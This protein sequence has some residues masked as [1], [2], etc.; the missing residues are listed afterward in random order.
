MNLES[1]LSNTALYILLFLIVAIAISYLVYFF[2]KDKEEFTGIQ[3]LTLTTVRFLYTF[4][5][6]FL[7]ISP[8]IELIKKRIEKPILILGIDNSE[9]MENDTTYRSALISLNENV[10][11]EAGD[12]F[13]IDYY[14]FG[15]TVTP[16]GTLTFS[17]KISNYSN[18]FNELE[19]RYFNLNIG[20]IIMAG[21]GIYNEGKNPVQEA[22]A[23]M[24]P[25]YT[26][27]IGDTLTDSDQAIIN[28]NHNPN[29]FMGNTFPLEIEALFKKVDAPSTQLSVYIENSLI[30]SEKID[31]P[32]PDYYYKKTLRLN[33]EEPGLQTVNVL[34]TPLPNE[35]N[36]ANNRAGFSI[37][38]HE[39]KYEVLVLTQSPHPDIGAI[40]ETLKQQAN[41]K[42]TN[43]DISTFDDTLSNFDIVVLNQLP[44]LNI[45]E[46][47]H[48]LSLKENT[49]L[50]VL[51]ITGPQTSISAFNNL[52]LGL[53]MAPSEITEESSPYFNAGF[54]LF[55]LPQN[56]NSV[57]PYYPPLLT[58]YTQ[59]EYSGEFAELAFQKING[60]EMDYPLI[61]T[62]EVDQRK[63]AVITGEGIWRWKLHEYQNTGKHQTFNQLFVSLFNYLCLK[64]EREQFKLEYPK[65]A[66]ETSPYKIKAQVFNEIY[67]PVTTTEVKL[68]LTDSTGAELNYIFDSDNISYNLNMGYLTP[69]KYSFIAST[70]LGEKTFKQSGNFNIQEINVEQ[71]N[72][73]ADFMLLKNISEQTGGKFFYP[74]QIDDLIN[75]IAKNKGIEIKIH[76][77]KNISEII[78]WKW[79]LFIVIF[80][81]SLEWFLRKFWGS[82]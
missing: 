63:T 32:Q 34:L 8:V 60:I 82:Y 44:S 6:V 25:I 80:L 68:I 62:G 26:I 47:K 39:N 48:F 76:N 49:T 11:S 14:T 41:F 54:S 33:A 52:N 37:E 7:I 56:I 5:I 66:P 79:Y 67:E 10:I 70:T 13:D 81:L 50:P 30:Y 23:L 29:V 36:T 3:R 65:I 22:P 58:W 21:D 12:K 59:Y 24:S 42:I 75:K 53:K 31:I 20:A 9:S 72:L 28:L 18:F 27:G 77:E 15:N 55:S 38:V 4:L 45:Q 43:S 61:L 2:R 74:S 51:V 57:A 73:K 71:N 69:G 16:K 78:D 64:K 35:S 1:A 40:S 19:K 46:N 17:E